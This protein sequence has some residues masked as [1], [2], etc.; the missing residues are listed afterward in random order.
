MEQFDERL[1]RVLFLATQEAGRLGDNAVEGRHF[2]IGLIKEGTGLGIMLLRNFEIDL[3]EILKILYESYPKNAGLKLMGN[4]PLSEEAQRIL[5]YAKQEAQQMGHMYVGTEHLLLGIMRDEQSES[6]QVLSS[7]E[8][9]IERVR[10]EVFAILSSNAVSKRKISKS[11]TPTLD[12]YSRD[13]TKLAESNKLDPIIGRETE[14]ERLMEVLC[15]RKKNNPALIGEPGVGKTAIVEGLAERIVSG[16]VPSFL[17]NT[18]VLAL[19]LAALV[20]GTK[21][22]GQFEERLKGLLR[23]IERSKNTVIFI[24]E[25]HTLVGAGAAEGAIDASSMLKPALARGELHCIGATTLNEYRKYIEKDGALERRFQVIQVD[26]PNLKETIQILRGLREKYEMHHG[27]RYDEAAL[28]AAANLSDKYI[29]NKCLP[30]KAIDIIDEAGSRVK[31]RRKS[32]KSPEIEEIEK[33]I[34]EL[35]VSKEQSVTNQKF[36]EAAKLRDELRKAEEKLNSMSQKETFPRVTQ[37]D[38]R[39]VISAWTGIPLVKLKQEEQERLLRIA[40]ELSKKVIGQD[41]AIKILAQA[42]RRSRTGL[43]ELKRPIGCFVFL[44]AHRSW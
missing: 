10:E 38:I 9:E 18:R 35:K 14:I 1:K 20:A 6:A 25:L 24:D 13:I 23:E 3:N 15:R 22:R 7:F 37:E 43:K 28:I 30:D 5:D 27:I 32:S 26:P 16:R 19:D 2:L 44:G 17:R 4:P 12:H 40:E 21:Y 29:S 33:S 11:K 31:L 34:E 39:E 41:E 36:E 42:I 8:L